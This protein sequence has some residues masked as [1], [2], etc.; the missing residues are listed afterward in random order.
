MRRSLRGLIDW[1]RPLG[2]LPIPESSIPLDL[3]SNIPVGFISQNSAYSTRQIFESYLQ[4][5]DEKTRKSALDVIVRYFIPGCGGPVPL[6]NPLRANELEAGLVYL[7]RVPL[8]YLQE[9]LTITTEVMRIYK[10]SEAQE[11]RVRRQIRPLLNWAREHDYLPFPEPKAKPEYPNAAEPPIPVGEMVYPKHEATALECFADYTLTLDAKQASSF[12]S[13]IAKYI[14]PALGGLHLSGQ[15]STAEESQAAL[16]F[17]ETIDMDTIQNLLLTATKYFASISIANQNKRVY[18][19]QVKRWLEWAVEKGYFG[20]VAELEITFRTFKDRPIERKTSP[21]GLKLNQEQAPVHQLGAKAFPNDYINDYLDQQFKDYCDYRANKP[22]KKVTPGALKGEIEK[23]RQF[24][25]WIHRY[26]EVALA[27]LCF[28]KLISVCQLKFRR[29]EYK[30]FEAFDFAKHSG[31]EHAYDTAD[32]DLKRIQR[33]LAFT[34]GKASSQQKRV[35]V[36]IA[37]AKFLY[38]GILGTDEFPVQQNIPI[39][40]RLLNLQKQLKDESNRQPATVKYHEKSVFW[41]QM[42]YVMEMQ[43]RRAEQ[44]IIYIQSSAAKLGYIEKKRPDT[45]MAQQLQ[46]FL[47]IAF[48]VIFPSRSRTFYDLE[49][50]KTFKEGYLYSNG[51]I[52]ADEL[53]ANGKEDMIRFYVHH[54]VDDY[55]TGSSM[56][57]VLLNNDGFWV[58]LPNLQ[59]D[60]KDLYGYVRQWLDWGRLARGPVNHNYFFRMAFSTRPVQG[61]SSWAQRIKWIIEWW[62][63]VRVPPAN[64]RKIFTG[65]YPEYRES[66]ALLLQHS[67][68]RHKYDYDLRTSVEK[69]APV[70]EANVDFINQ[71]LMDIV[72]QENKDLPDQLLDDEAD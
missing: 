15:R 45:A 25:G 22:G 60:N 49:I 61:S 32:E 30:D 24:T 3:C 58:E 8:E 10:R 41:S 66:A 57:T 67:E 55:K 13:I 51:F 65:Q 63:G 33:Y 43:R 36:M 56:P 4:Q 39:I 27:D 70:V 71:T 20:Y 31:E 11:T 37:M 38:R 68:D 9:A 5:L 19:S 14:V 29:L 2:Y 69:M 44:D 34:G 42:I 59:F 52:P 12:K 46:R 35:S 64:I 54:G 16:A 53:R 21:S 50:G 47:S 6:H 7:E 17:L 40:L 62:T 18:V 23:I 28:E 72:K 26:E 1:A 48:S